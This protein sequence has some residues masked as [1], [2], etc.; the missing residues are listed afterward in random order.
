MP[1]VGMT[2]QGVR[3][4]FIGTLRKGAKKPDD[5]HPGKDLGELLRFVGAD[6]TIDDEWVAVFGGS[7]VEELQVSLPYQTVD[8]V[9][10]AWREA[11]VAGGLVRRC[12]GEKIVRW[13]DADGEMQDQPQ[14]CLSP[15]CDCKPNGRLEVIVPALRRLGTVL[16]VTT[17]VHDI[18]SIDGCL[19][20]LQMAFG[21]LRHVPLI[22]KRVPRR[23]STPE[24]VKS[25]N[26]YVRTGKRQRREAWL[27]HLE[28]A[29]QWVQH[30]LETMAVPPALAV[31]DMR[32]LPA[33]DDDEPESATNG[34]GKDRSDRADW[35]PDSWTEAIAECDSIRDLVYGNEALLARAG[36]IDE[37]ARKAN[38]IALIWRR[39][40]ELALAFVP[41]AMADQL[42][43]LERIAA[44]IPAG[45]I[46]LGDLQN[47]LS[48]AR[49]EIDAM[50][51]DTGGVIDG[52]A[53]NVDD[54]DPPPSAPANGAHQPA[55]A[56]AESAPPARYTD[57][58]TACQGHDQLV[59]LGDE[60]LADFAAGAVNV[61]HAHKAWQL[62]CLRWI[63]LVRTD[64]DLDALKGWIVGDICGRTGGDAAPFARTSQ[65]QEVMKA[66]QAARAALA[67]E[68]SE[69]AAKDVAAYQAA[70][71]KQEG[72]AVA[73]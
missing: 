40:V 57:R 7:E 66:A 21:D 31:N 27:L 28:P 6:E 23:I 30:M 10:Q 22:L 52:Q 36:L 67:G 46:G 54:Q 9:W 65:G 25:G 15:D 20:G 69:Q 8:E 53:T 39:V 17:S 44:G 4:P 48:N 72:E 55:D 71:A 68:K 38:V 58:V 16:V 70:V 18:M 24:M 33:P 51:G 63:H 1:I 73:V 61:Y 50:F 19:R 62:W 3:W 42:A 41:T 60:M 56:E 2:G 34:N 5:K 43:G 64:D 45:T 35:E 59:E 47:A 13:R 37:A 32:A 26:D 12:T 11:Y 49:A 29:P 14:P